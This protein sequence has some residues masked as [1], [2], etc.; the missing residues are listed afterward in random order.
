MF[1]TCH[2][3]GIQRESVGMSTQSTRRFEEHDA[4]PAFSS[5]SGGEV[6]RSGEAGDTPTDDGNALRLLIRSR[7]SMHQNVWGYCYFAAMKPILTIYQTQ[8]SFFFIFAVCRF[9][10]WFLNRG[11]FSILFESLGLGSPKRKPCLG[12][13]KPISQT[14]FSCYSGGM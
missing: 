4:A 10:T 7:S 3:F 2:A 12:D 6:P 11:F 14:Q 1:T 5:L 13:P 9:C 8:I